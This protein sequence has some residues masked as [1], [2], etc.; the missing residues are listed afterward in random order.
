MAKESIIYCHKCNLSN[1]QPTSINEYF[2][3]YNSKQQSVK[4][5]EKNICA[6]CE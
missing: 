3:T 2:H 1:Q 4:F 5:N 6:A